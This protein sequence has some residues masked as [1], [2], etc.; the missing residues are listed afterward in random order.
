MAA[1][2]VKANSQVG[3]IRCGRQQTEGTAAQAGAGTDVWRQQSE[4]VTRHTEGHAGQTLKSFAAE[5]VPAM[6]SEI[7]AEAHLL[8]DLS[9]RARFE[10]ASRMAKLSEA[11]R[12]LKERK[13]GR[14][15]AP[16]SDDDA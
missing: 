5:A 6:I 11:D 2:A 10:D 8:L 7:A 4:A 16:R 14:R 13:R 3:H 12:H 15:V 9:E 1:T